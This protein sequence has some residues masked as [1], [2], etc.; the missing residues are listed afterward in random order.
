MF[1]KNDIS[2][3]ECL[4]LMED[5]DRKIK[6][7]QI[8]RTELKCRIDILGVHERNKQIKE[9]EEHYKQCEENGMEF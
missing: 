4:R 8:L 6:A 3:E 7:L 1:I 2:K 5:C 9:F